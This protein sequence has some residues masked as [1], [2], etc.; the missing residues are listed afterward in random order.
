[1]YRVSEL[2]GTDKTLPFFLALLPAEGAA[3]A[4][5]RYCVVLFLTT[6]KTS[7]IVFI[8]LFVCFLTK[9]LYIVQVLVSSVN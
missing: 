7:K 3:M 4:A 9:L 8:S 5:D 1:M 2:S 6:Q